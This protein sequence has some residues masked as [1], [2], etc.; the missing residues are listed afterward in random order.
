MDRYFRRVVG[1]WVALSCSSVVVG[2]LAL[3]VWDIQEHNCLLTVDSEESGIHGDI[4][5]CSYSSATKSLYVAAGGVAALSLK[6]RS[7]AAPPCSV[8]E[9][10]L[11]FSLNSS[12]KNLSVDL[13]LF[14][15]DHLHENP[16]EVCSNSRL[17]APRFLFCFFSSDRPR[18]H[19]RLIISHEEPVVCCGFCEEFRQ[20]VSCGEG[21]VCKKKEPPPPDTACALIKSLLEMIS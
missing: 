18:P 6:T 5:A 21:S 13:F 9:R 4:T 8:R 1:G 3:Q 11:S 2:L 17:S 20:V 10:A 14:L 19:S 16:S 15:R 7:A 12:E